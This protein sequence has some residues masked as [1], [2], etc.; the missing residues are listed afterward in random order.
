MSTQF[1]DPD[2]LRTALSLATR[3]PSV[4]NSQPWHWKIGDE[5]LHLYADTTRH[6]I[7][8]DP[9]QRDLLLSC[10]AALH[11]AVV[12]LAALG[13]QS[14]IT[15]LPNPADPNHLASIQV[16]RQEPGELDILLAAAIP[17]RR[18]DRRLFSFWPVSRAD[19]ATIGVR[20]ARMGV[21]MRR[22]EL[23]TDL[24]AVL[25]EA[26]WKHVHD[27][28]Y[29]DELTVWS[30]RYSSR[31]GVPARNIPDSDSRAAIPG[32]LFAGAALD[33]PAD[34][35]ARH[36]HAVVLAL[37]T[38]GDDAVARVRAGEAT[39]MALLTSTALGL[40]SCP[41]TEPLEIVNTRESIRS[42]VFGGSEYPQ[43]MLRVGWA[44]IGA[45][46]LP[47]TPRFPLEDVV[48]TLDGSHI[49]WGL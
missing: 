20:V 2:T 18:T 5:S 19:I 31:A 32:R 21:Q 15:R 49:P 30:G 17:R 33:Q 38:S 44:P 22:V 6:L 9:D 27:R 26:V 41:V 13:W 45:D 34:T 42:E 39:S 28:E 11:H 46:P 8:T 35:P 47:A 48:D 29:L 37:G 16:K 24:R 10:G 23:S 40:S 43:V 25:A 12:G 1:P 36:D 3:A 14:R 4:H 7:H